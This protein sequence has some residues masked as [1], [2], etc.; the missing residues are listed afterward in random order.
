MSLE[1]APIDRAPIY[2]FLLALHSNYVR[3]PYFVP[4]VRYSQILAKIAVLADP[5]SIWRPRWGLHFRRD[6]WH[7]KTRRIALSYGIKYHNIT[8]SLFTTWHTAIA[9]HGDKMT[10]K[11]YSIKFDI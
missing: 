9:V 1:I 7:Q 2:E 8:Y 4:F 3:C 5:T 10:D 11:N 6:L